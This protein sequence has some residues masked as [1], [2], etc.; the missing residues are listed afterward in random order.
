[1]SSPP[2]ITISLVNT[3]NRELLLACLASLRGAARRVTLQTIVIDNASTDG[4]AEAVRAAYPQVEIVPVSR[5]QGFGANHN[6]AI[7]RARGRYVLIL[8]EDTE[9][10]E[11][12]L[13]RLCDFLDRNPRVAAA[14]PRILYPD[15]REQPSAFRFPTPGRVALTTLTL[16][17]AGWI[18]SGGSRIRGVDWVCGAAIL[19]RTEA[20]REVGGFDER[21]FIYSEDPDLCRRL[22]DRGWGVAYFPHASLVHHENATT[23]GVPERR[24]YQ[25]ERSRAIYTRKH[26]GR[27]GELAVRALTAAAFG[28]RAGIAK[29]LLIVPGGRRLKPLDPSAPAQFLTHARAAIDPNGRPGIEQAAAE[30]NASRAAR[31]GGS[32]PG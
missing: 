17:R 10:H 7:R 20:L 4:S 15:G 13:D 6:E 30:F 9:L 32:P 14:G 12:S 27:S 23:T 3:D 18:Q 1:M 31:D 19:A 24:I 22:R 11:A 26:H 29:G 28:A 2:D 8:N 21:L 25:M 16:Q 5:R